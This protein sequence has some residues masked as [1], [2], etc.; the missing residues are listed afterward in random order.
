MKSR[1]KILKYIAAVGLVVAVSGYAYIKAHPLIFNESFFE[2]A[3]CIDIADG[4]MQQYAHDHGGQFP[5]STDGYGDA[6]LLLVAD[7]PHSAIFFTGPCFDEKPFVKAIKNSSHM[8]ESECGRV[9]VQGLTV[10]N[11]P[12]I[13]LLF[14]K[15]PTPGGDH[16]H[17]WDRFKMP[18]GREVLLIGGHDWVDETNWPPYSSNQVKL[19]VQAGFSRKKAEDL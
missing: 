11:S 19:L 9:Y 4:M 1:Y 17:M 12:A 8:P 7:D 2:H 5:S 14:D 16:C 10:S 3:H 15:I 18:L 13:V 6:L